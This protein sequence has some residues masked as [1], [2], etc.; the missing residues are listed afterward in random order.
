MTHELKL[1]EEWLK[2]HKP[3]ICPSQADT[4]EPYKGKLLS[5]SSAQYDKWGQRIYKHLDKTN[6]DSIDETKRNYGD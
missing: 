4:C 5:T 1:Q 2:T 3:T 6:A